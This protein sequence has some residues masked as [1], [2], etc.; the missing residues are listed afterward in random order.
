[1]KFM[2]NLNHPPIFYQPLKVKRTLPKLRA[3]PSCLLAS[4]LWC[5]CL[6]I[7]QQS[8]HDAWLFR[9]WKRGGPGWRDSRSR[10]MEDKV[11]GAFTIHRK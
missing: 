6:Q 8:L 10:F 11:L 9:G 2:L 3:W 1:M 4:S 5:G 7:Y